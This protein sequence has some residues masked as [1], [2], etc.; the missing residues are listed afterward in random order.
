MSQDPFRIR[1]LIHRARKSEYNFLST[2]GFPL[3]CFIGLLQVF[4]LTHNGCFSNTHC[5]FSIPLPAEVI[6]VLKRLPANHVLKQS[7]TVSACYTCKAKVKKLEWIQGHFKLLTFILDDVDM[8]EK[9]LQFPSTVCWGKTEASKMGPIYYIFSEPKS[10]SYTKFYDPFNTHWDLFSHW[11]FKRFPFR[12]SIILYGL[13]IWSSPEF[14]NTDWFSS[15]VK[16][17]LCYL[18]QRKDLPPNSCNDVTKWR[19]WFS[20]LLGQL[21]NILIHTEFDLHKVSLK[22]LKSNLP[23]VYVCHICCWETYRYCQGMADTIGFL[24]RS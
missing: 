16:I 9:R 7:Y 4:A 18:I 13:L 14:E 17:G 2:N 20:V 6:S 8:I 21:L 1:Q 11:L 15:W 24:Q 3:S 10:Y 23:I 5:G 12:N 19:I 22:I